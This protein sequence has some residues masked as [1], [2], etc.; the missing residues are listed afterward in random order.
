MGEPI[1]QAARP[2]PPN[3]SFSYPS[4]APVQSANTNAN[5]NAYSQSGMGYGAPSVPQQP[6]QNSGYTQNLYGQQQPASPYGMP[7]TAAPYP[8]SPNSMGYRQPAPQG[9]I[10][11]ARL[12]GNAATAA[13]F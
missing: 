7:N 4:S 12:W 8:T 11:Y 6:V 10:R 2:V 13:R 9:W 5:Y 1:W 3:Q